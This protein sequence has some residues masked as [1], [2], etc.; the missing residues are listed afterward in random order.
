MKTNIKAFKALILK[1]ESI[2]EEDIEK[3][4]KEHQPLFIAQSLTG[5]GYNSTCTLCLEARKLACIDNSNIYCEY[6]IWNK[7]EHLT[8]DYIRGY[9]CINNNNNLTWRLIYFNPTNI[10]NYKNRAKLM[11]EVLK[12]LGYK[13]PK[14]I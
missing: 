5:F 7:H 10:H 2:T 6:C 1:Y 11:R 12:K 14:T 9:S 3:A 13:Q 4:E 8:K